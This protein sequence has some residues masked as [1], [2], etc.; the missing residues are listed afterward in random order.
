MAGHKAH[1]SNELKTHEME[2]Q[3]KDRRQARTGKRAGM[4]HQIRC[5]GHAEP[6]GQMPTQCNDHAISQ[7]MTYQ[8]PKDRQ[9]MGWEQQQGRGK[10]RHRQQ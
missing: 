7:D 4:E 3:R 9:G 8:E 5:A 6:S 10:S 1:A 2:R